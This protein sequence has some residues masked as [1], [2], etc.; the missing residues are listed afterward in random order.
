MKTRVLIT[1]LML[2]GIN[3]LAQPVFEKTYSE[4]ANISHLESKGQVYF[5]M[6]VVNKQ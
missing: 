4:S 3:L 1:S 6:D 2:A 5:T